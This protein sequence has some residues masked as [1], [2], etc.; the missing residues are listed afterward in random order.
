[1]GL[2]N[3]AFGLGAM[4]GPL[5]AGAFFDLLGGYAVAFV[6]MAASVVVS[7]VIVSAAARRPPE[8]PG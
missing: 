6:L 5:L 8:W 7:S 2:Q 4:L 1:L 3:I